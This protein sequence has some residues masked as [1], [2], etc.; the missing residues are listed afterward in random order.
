MS[1]LKPHGVTVT[2]FTC[3]A[4][5]EDIQIPALVESRRRPAEIHVAVDAAPIR[6]HIKQLHPELAL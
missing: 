4:C 1:K 3:P 2:Q 5:G 6:E